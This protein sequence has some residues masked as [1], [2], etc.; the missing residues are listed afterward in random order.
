MCPCE[1]KQKVETFTNSE[2]LNK[3][4]NMD[5]EIKKFFGNSKLIIGNK[6]YRLRHYRWLII[7]ILLS[8][9][10]LLLLSFRGETKIVPSSPTI[11]V[12]VPT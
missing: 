1:E 10:V 8:I 4:S 9:F 11:M 2:A 12:P 3:I 6:K 5:N 7:I